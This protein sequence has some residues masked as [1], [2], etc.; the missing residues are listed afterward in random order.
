MRAPHHK[1]ALV[2]KNDDRTAAHR[3]AGGLVNVHQQRLGGARI[4]DG[5]AVGHAR[6]H[7]YVREDGPV[8][9]PPGGIDLG[10]S[11]VQT[12]DEQAAEQE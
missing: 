7:G 3:V 11:R 5:R 12:N 10:G 9:A 1:A 8:V 4:V 2:R 6:S